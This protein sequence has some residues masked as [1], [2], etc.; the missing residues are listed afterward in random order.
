MPINP[1]TGLW[2]ASPV[3][4]LGYGGLPYGYSPYGAGLLPRPPY[5]TEGGYGGAPYGTGSY[6]SLDTVYPW[7]TSAVSIDGN[8]IEV[9]FSEE[10]LIDATLLNAASY[11]LTPTIGAPSTVTAAVAGTIGSFG[12]ATSVILT[13]TGTTLCGNYLVTIAGAVQDLHGNPITNPQNQA[14]LYTLGEPATFTVTPT[15]GDALR[16]QFTEAMLTEAQFTPGIEALASYSLTSSYPVPLAIQSITHPAGNSNSAVDMVVSGQTSVAYTAEVT[17]ATA[18]SYDATYLPSAATTFTGTESGTGSSF[19]GVAGL[20]LT[21][22]AGNTY[23]WGFADTSGKLL[24]T[25]SY[26]VDFTF[27]PSVA[28]FAPL[29]FNAVL[30]SLVVSD[31]AI[32]VSI[33]IQRLA[34]IDVI[35]VVS[36]AYSVQV[37]ASWSTGPTTISLVRNQKADHY[38]LLIN[39]VPLVSSATAAFTG[40]PSIPTGAQF[41]LGSTYDV[42][43]L[44]ISEITFTSTQTVFTAAW[45]FLHGASTTFT[46]SA[47]LTKDHFFT[48]RGPLVKGWGDGTPADENDVTVQVNATDVGIDSVNPYIGKITPTVPIPIMPAG[49]MTVDVDYKWFPAPV[50]EMVG[51]NTEGLILNKWNLPRGHHTPPASPMPAQATGTPD[52][53]RFPMGIV[54][55]PLTRARPIHI[56]HR[57]IGFD[58]GYTAALNSPT[59]MLLNRNPHRVRIDDLEEAPEGVSVAFEGDTTPAQAET[60]WSIEGTDTGYVGIGSQAG[61]YVLIDASAG[62]YAVGTAA[63]YYQE[64]DF[65]HPMSAVVAGRFQVDS[66]TL[67]GV[68]TGVGFGLHNN[69]HLFVM[70]CLVINGLKHI[71]LLTDG[72]KPHLAASWNIGP[73]SP[74][75]ITSSQTFSVATSAFPD[76][77]GA[78]TKIQIL[79]G[80]QAGIYT[81]STAV[82]QTNGTTTVTTRTAF[83]ADPA[84]WGN[85]T[86]TV[87]Y[88]VRWD[89]GMDTYRMVA[90]VDG[91]TAELYLG[92]ALSGL[93]LTLTKATAY[94]AQTSLMLP[95]GELG[96]VFWGSLS[97]PT[98]NQ[99]QW[100]FYRY[101]TTPDTTTEHFQGIVVAA[102]MGAKPEDDANHE[103]FITQDF[104]YSEI[105]SSGNT[106]LLKALS[107]STSLDLSF[108][109]GRVEPFLTTQTL[110]DVDSIFRMDSGVGLDAEITIE[111][112]ERSVSLSTLFYAEGGSPYR[113]MVLLP[114]VSLSGLRVPPS[115]GWAASSGL[116]TDASCRGQILTIT[117]AI[118]ELGTYYKDITLNSSCAGG[119]YIEGRLA[120]T[121]YTANG[122]GEMGPI[123]GGEVGTAPAARI[124]A[125]AFLASPARVMLTSD[126]TPVASFSFDWTDGEMHTYRVEAD[127]TTSLATL[128]VDDTTLGTADLTLFQL[129]TTDTMAFLGTFGTDVASTVDWDATSFVPMPLTSVKRTL[130]IYKEGSRA[131]IDSWVLPRTDGTTAL[132]SSVTAI[133]REMDWRSNMRLRLRLDPTWGAVL[134]RPDLPPPPFFTG[135]FATQATE[136]SAGWMTLEY[137]LLPLSAQTFGRVQFG[138]LDPATVSQQRWREVRYRIYTTPT[139]DV[140]T[141]H[142]M[143]LNQFNVITS[144]ELGRDITIE[145]VEVTSLS[146]TLVSLKP[147]HIFADRVFSVAVGGL[148]IPSAGWSFD[149]DTQAITLLVALSSDHVDVTVTFAPGKPVTNTYLEAQ[150]FLESVT[151]L[152]EGTPPFEMSHVAT[153]TSQVVFGSKINDPQDLLGTPDF[154][155][156]DP[157]R[158]LEFTDTEGACYEALDFIQVNDGADA[159]LPL[160]TFCDGPT[161]E[162]GLVGIALEGQLLT[163]QHVSS[164]TMS[165]GPFNQSVILHASGGGYTGGNLGPGTAVLYPSYPA[166][167]GVDVGGIL[168]SMSWRMRLTSVITDTTGPVEQALAETATLAATVDNVPPTYAGDVDPNPNGVAGVAAH[169]ACVAEMSEGASLYSRLGPWG[170]EAALAMESQLYGT[171]ATQPT[172]VPASGSGLVLQGG[173]ALGAPVLTTTNVVA[174]N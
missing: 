68:F 132:N 76:V 57:F 6:G 96:R 113:S 174:A 91:G 80:S 167:A 36:G 41:L 54:L 166:I 78:G 164:S 116:S 137:P 77:I 155:M 122:T 108:G 43:Q 128:I 104:G 38:G 84:L 12:G 126:G 32:E 119:R 95:T 154:I 31:G 112:G 101:G 129:T 125:V 83:P 65:K 72:S 44:P 146:S 121:S 48:A 49:G 127:P 27:D 134:Y 111:N 37:P 16:F 115:E 3:S 17:P 161:P 26:R 59:S 2:V 52:V 157:F 102:E 79:E 94:P 63:L 15:A 42:T 92:G 24:P 110:V 29:L 141:P 71:G 46:G 147:A 120:I 151:K 90:D 19:V 133:V 85:N 143:V 14:S 8:T 98:T 66:Y 159:G 50:M 131:S 145:S 88:Q 9:F 99:S 7:V 118:G 138:A 60:S 40:V 165:D 136:P 47:A 87:Y 117:Q 123:F 70:G 61:S 10:M 100:T 105:D 103:W 34:G 152:N 97:R 45:N 168:K 150:P 20:L 22:L 109:Y 130:G 89:L 64:A 30:G 173:S 1:Y 163:E 93:A 144:G 13:H 18:I 58:K 114:S 142:H 74:I 5:S 139:E 140:I 39:G 53:A 73:S 86:A 82:A 153:A 4:G 56:G 11:T 33:L 35:E 28:V 160:S 169:G 25:S 156:N 107:G 51:L 81:L 75:T 106:L 23:G 124:V 21:K 158:T 162:C 170:G 55:P 135:D 149:E 171:S 67:D 172:G 69:K 62:S 148:I